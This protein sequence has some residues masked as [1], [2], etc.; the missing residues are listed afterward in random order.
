[1]QAC[2]LNVRQFLKAL[3][4]LRCRRRFVTRTARVENDGTVVSYWPFSASSK[5]ARAS[6][7]RPAL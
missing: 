1:M 7:T 6:S 2:S 5:S 3:G 4:D